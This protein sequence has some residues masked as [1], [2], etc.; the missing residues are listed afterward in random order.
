MRLSF[1]GR[2]KAPWE[3]S[4]VSWLSQ[5]LLTEMFS[6]SNLIPIGC[7]LNKRG[8][9]RE[10]KKGEGEREGDRERLLSFSGADV[11]HERV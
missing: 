2:N 9:R 1:F 6:P 8:R 10:G 7:G 3:D 5:L 4:N 11:W